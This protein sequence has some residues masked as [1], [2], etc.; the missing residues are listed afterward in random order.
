MTE[1][2]LLLSKWRKNYCATREE[3][4]RR[5][6]E[7]NSDSEEDIL[8]KEKKIWTRT[9]PADL[10]YQRD[11]ENPKII[12]GTQRLSK[13]CET[14]NDELVSRA[15]KINAI[16]PKYEPPPRKNRARICKHKSES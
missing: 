12:R 3:V 15:Q 1:R 5:M 13:I 16:K 9:T 8:E 14:F 4:N 10:Y 2:E 7:M 11:E 6:E